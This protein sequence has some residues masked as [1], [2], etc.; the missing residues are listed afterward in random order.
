M[1]GSSPEEEHGIWR[2][3]ASRAAKAAMGASV[4]CARAIVRD[5]TGDGEPEVL[6][7]EGASLVIFVRRDG[8]WVGQDAYLD[9]GGAEAAFDRGEI[10]TVAPILPDLMIGDRRVRPPGPPTPPPPQPA[11]ANPTAK[12]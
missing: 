11:P 6:I 9:V 10:E 1:Y 3:L 7:R 2:S 4:M 8:L 5:L 12:P